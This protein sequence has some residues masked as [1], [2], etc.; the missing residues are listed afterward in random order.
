MNFARH[1]LTSS[2]P[3][4][5]RK[6]L[7]GPGLLAL[8]VGV[9]MASLAGGQTAPAAG[10]DSSAPTLYEMP[11]NSV[12]T[13]WYTFENPKG[14]KGQAAQA[15]FGRKGAPATAVAAGKSLVLADIE[16]SGTIRRIWGTLFHRNPAALRGLKIEMYWD[17]AKTPAVQA[18]FGDFF[19]HSLGHMVTFENACFSS[20]EGRS[21]NCVVPMPFRKSAR[22]VLVNE[23]GSNNGIYYEVDATR[24]DQHS[25]SALYFHS[26][27]RRENMTTLRRDMTI[28]PHVEGRGRFLGCNLGVRLHPGRLNFWWGEGEVK[29]YLDGDQEF[30]TLCGTGTEDYIGDGYGQ[31]HFFNRFSGNQY[32]SPTKNAYGFYRLHVPDP[33]WFHKDARV[34][35]QVM[36]GP[37]Y[38]AMLD[39]MDKDPSLKFM[40]AGDGTQYYTR[41][42][43]AA[44]PKRAEVMERIDDYCAT[45]YWYMDRPENGLPPLAPAPER[46]KDLP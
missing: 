6:L 34:T 45:A 13:R 16:G 23:S 33:V 7:V 42:E 28:L 46:M 3:P 35:I 12:E 8:A 20:P 14:L 31:E 4:N 11:A 38:K 27:W 32:I 15:R 2:L 9:L 17:G 43:L 41:E 19:C 36:G 18:P 24:G 10:P 40:K 5:L 22:I 39:A 25:A 1:I 26:Y 29:V 37:S 30:P 44:E 21:F